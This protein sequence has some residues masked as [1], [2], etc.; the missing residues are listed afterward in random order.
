IHA[1]DTYKLFLTELEAR[2][3][4]LGL[5]RFVCTHCADM[6]TIPER[7]QNIDLLWS[8]GA[9]YSI[10]F[11]HALTSW[12]RAVKPG[13]FVVV[14]ELCWSS[15]RPPAP[16]KDFFR[17]EYPAM[18]SVEANLA[19][20]EKAGYRVLA[21]HAL[22]SSAWTEGFYD[23]LK[24]RARKLLAHPD[25]EVKAYARHMTTEIE[26]FERS[27]GSYGYTFFVLQTAAS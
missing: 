25:D 22:P 20:A 16:V 27:E 3:R 15:D 17:S 1:F 10:G 26:M 24:P 12:T 13:G 14:S 2:S 18:K 6:R 23:V 7:F 19:L 8:E 5:D 11:E 4:E 21:T 9:A